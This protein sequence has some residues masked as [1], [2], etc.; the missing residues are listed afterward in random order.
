MKI[1]I[2]GVA[3]P[4]AGRLILALLDEEANLRKKH[5]RLRF[6]KSREINQGFI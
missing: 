4:A 1:P 6:L 3:P 5:Q 2:C